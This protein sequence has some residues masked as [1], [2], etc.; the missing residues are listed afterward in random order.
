M[1]SNMNENANMHEN[2]NANL[3]S[4]NANANNMNE[5]ALDANPACENGKAGAHRNFSAKNAKNAETVGEA[6]TSDAVNETVDENQAAGENE[7]DASGANGDEQNR[8]MVIHEE[9]AV[10]MSGPDA[11]LNIAWCSPE[12]M[13]AENCRELACAAGKISFLATE[14]MRGRMPPSVLSR[15]L[16]I[17]DV[18]CIV[19][20]GKLI[21]G[22]KSPLGDRSINAP[23]NRHMPVIIRSINAHVLSKKAFNAVVGMTVGH[24]PIQTSMVLRWD[25][26]KWE[27]AFFSMC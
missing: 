17:H 27:A 12:D 6:E 19:R 20:T 22:T 24:A 2:E 14:V 11:K 21:D 3:N 8:Q 18:N 26:A 10:G 7:T 16:G 1:N 5:N 9:I 25:G 13:S 15:I 23:C 4:D